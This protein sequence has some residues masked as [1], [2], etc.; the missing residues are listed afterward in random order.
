[1]ED[2]LIPII[3]EMLGWREGNLTVAMN[4]GH[5]ST[6]WS[7]GA[8]LLISPKPYHQH[9]VTGKHHY[10]TLGERTDQRTGK[11]FYTIYS[12]AVGL[13]NRQDGC[14]SYCQD[15]Q[16]DPDLEGCKVA[17]WAWVVGRFREICEDFTES[18]KNNY[19]QYK[20]AIATN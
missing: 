14:C 1:M 12:V 13:D 17:Q 20:T 11:P 4:D 18:F 7:T 9:S 5:Y 6:T 15:I 19:P 3:S 2:K 10:L 8:F 16:P